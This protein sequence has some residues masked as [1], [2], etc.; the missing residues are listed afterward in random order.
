MT[1]P[2]N[3]DV[4]LGVNKFNVDEEHPHIIMKTAPDKQ[5]L[6]V[7][8]KA[9]PAGLYKS[10]MT[11]ACALIMPDAWSAERVEFS[12]LIRRWKNG[13]THAAPSAWSFVTV[14]EYRYTLHCRMAA[15]TPYPA[16]GDK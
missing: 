14:N 1:S 7:L 4:K 2:V 13:S 3:V 15:K 11:A 12:D 8:I 5:V 9:C 6:E 16:Y 10:R